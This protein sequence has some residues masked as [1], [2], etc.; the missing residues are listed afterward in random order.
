M[1]SDPNMYSTFG[2]DVK[3]TFSCQVSSPSELSD[4][5]FYD[6]TEVVAATRRTF[7]DGKTK[8]ELDL[9]V[10][11]VD[12]AGTYSCR[13][14]AEETSSTSTL[15]VMSMLKELPSNVKENP[16]TE[17]VLTCRAEWNTV[18]ANKPVFTWLKDGTTATETQID[19]EDPG[20]TWVESTLP[21]TLSGNAEFSCQATYADLDAGSFIIS[22]TTVIANSATV[23][24]AS[25]QIKRVGETAQF[26]CVVVAGPSV[27]IKWRKRAD[28]YTAETPKYTDLTASSIQE[29]YDPEKSSRKSTLTVG[30]GNTLALTDTSDSIECYDS[31]L[32]ISATMEL[33]VFEITELVSMGVVKEETA[34]L[35]CSVTVFDK[36]PVVTW[37]KKD[38]IA[39]VLEEG[40]TSPRPG[41]Y[42]LVIE[43]AEEIDNG[44]YYCKVTYDETE[45]L[46]PSTFK[47][48]EVNFYVRELDPVPTTPVYIHTGEAISLDCTVG[49]VEEAAGSSDIKWYKDGTLV[50]QVEGVVKVTDHAYDGVNKNQKITYTDTAVDKDDG[51]VY[52]CE[53]NFKYGDPISFE[54]KVYVHL[55]TALDEAYSN[56]TELSCEFA[57]S[58]EPTITWWKVS[59]GEGEEEA[60]LK[61]IDPS[62]DE[63]A[64]FSLTPGTWQDKTV[65][66]KLNIDLVKLKDTTVVTCKLVFTDMVETEN[67]DVADDPRPLETQTTINKRE[68]T[69]KTET[70]Y[71]TGGLVTMECTFFYGISGIG[72]SSVEWTG[73]DS[74]AEAEHV[75]DEG[76]NTDGSRTT[77]LKFPDTND[78][79]YSGT[80][81]CN[82]VYSDGKGNT[83]E[84]YKE[85]IEVITRLITVDPDTQG[86][87]HTNAGFSVTCTFAGQETPSAVTWTRDGTPLT[88]GSG[89]YTLEYTIGEKKAELAKT[90]PTS[91]DDGVYSCTFTMETAGDSP[92]GSTTITV[93]LLTMTQSENYYGAVGG[94]LALACSM[95]SD[96]VV[97]IYWFKDGLLKENVAEEQLIGGVLSSTLLITELSAAEDDGVYSC[98]LSNVADQDTHMETSTTTVTLTTL[99]FTDEPPAKTFGMT[100]VD[101]RIT[102]KTNYAKDQGI[103]VDVV[104]L[105]NDGSEP[106]VDG[107]KF[108]SGAA[109]SGDTFVS[110]LT[111]SYSADMLEK[112]YS[113][114]FTFSGEN[115]GTSNS[116]TSSST[117]ISQM[118]ISGLED[119]MYVESGKDVTFSCKALGGSATT[120]FWTKDGGEYTSEIVETPKWDEE[121]HSISSTI[122]I[123]GAG[124]EDDGLY[125]CRHSGDPSVTD[126][127]TVDV[128]E[129]VL[130]SI[131]VKSDAS[132]T[133]TCTVKDITGIFTFAWTDAN[134]DSV[135]AKSDTQID[136]NK[137]MDSELTVTP[138]SD[139][140]Y[141]CTVTDPLGNKADP[142]TAN[143]KVFEITTTNAKVRT[144]EDAVLTC[145]ISGITE[146]VTVV[147]SDGTQDLETESGVR[148]IDPGTPLGAGATTQTATMTLY[149][150]ET[151]AIFICKV[152]SGEFPQSKTQTQEVAVNLFGI[153]LNTKYTIKGAGDS[154]DLV[155]TGEGG[156][157][158]KIEW[159][160]TG[161]EEVLDAVLGDYDPDSA[162]RT[163]TFSFTNLK[164]S[165]S[166]EYTCTVTFGEGADEKVSS[167]T[168]IDVVEITASSDIGEKTG[169]DAV[170]SCDYNTFSDAVPT[171]KWFQVN[172]AGGAD[173]EQQASLVDNDAS[174]KSIL[175]L[176]SVQFDQSGQ[177]YYCQIEYQETA[178]GASG[179]S[180]FES[181]P[182]T[183]Y[184]REFVT[185]APT[186]TYVHTG[187][188]VSLVCDLKVKTEAELE[189][190]KWYK[191][192]V[193]VVGVNLVDTAEYDDVNTLQKTTY[194]DA[195]PDKTEGGVYKC[196]YNFVVG[197]AI[198]LEFT[199]A[200]HLLTKLP[201]ITLNKETVRCEFKGTNQPVITWYT[202]ADQEVETGGESPYTTSPGTW[203]NNAV[204]ATLSIDKEKYKE[205]AS[206]TCK[207]IFSPADITDPLETTTAVHFREISVQ[208]ETTYT[209]GDD[210]MLSCVFDFTKGGTG[211]TTVTWS[212]VDSL[213]V[214][215]E[216]TLDLGSNGADGTRTSTLTLKNIDEAKYA[217]DYVCNFGYSDTE[218]Y[219]SEEIDVVVRLVKVEATQ[220]ANTPTNFK[221]TC[222]FLGTEKPTSVTWSFTGENDSDPTPVTKDSADF[223]LALIKE[224]TQAVLTKGSPDDVDTGEYTCEWAF[225]DNPNL[226]TSGTQNLYVALLKMPQKDA[227]PIHSP[228][229]VAVTVTCTVLAAETRN[230]YWYKGDT[231]LGTG[232]ETFQD[233]VVTSEYVITSFSNSDLGSY[234]CRLTNDGSTVTAARDS[235]VLAIQGLETTPAGAGTVYIEEEK[236]TTLSCT[237][238]HRATITWT[239]DSVTFDAAEIYDA[240]DY[241]SETDSTTS[242][243]SF[244]S[245]TADNEGVYVCTYQTLS[246]TFTIDTFGVEVT[247][248]EVK[249]GEETEL[250]CKVTGV[251]SLFGFAWTNQDSGS[252]TSEDDEKVSAENEVT[253]TVTV[254]PTGDTTYTCSITDPNGAAAASKTVTL[255]VFEITDPVETIAVVGTATSLVCGVTGN[256]GTPSYKWYKVGQDTPVFTDPGNEALS[257]Y[258]ISNPQF[259]DDGAYKCTVAMTV[260]DVTNDAF[261]SNTAELIVKLFPKELTASFESETTVKATTDFLQCTYKGDNDVSTV[262]W[263]GPGGNIDE[264][265]V[266]TAEY[267]EEDNTIVTKFTFTNVAGGDAGDYTC[268]FNFDEASITPMSKTTSVTIAVLTAWD[269]ITLNEETLDCTFTGTHE[270]SSLQWY[271]G[272]NVPVV[273]TQGSPYSI[274]DGAFTDNTQTSTLTIDKALYTD[275]TTF[276]CKI[277][278]TDIF[279]GSSDGLSISTAVHFREIK[280]FTPTTYTTGEDVTI[281]CVLDFTK[282]GTGPTSVEWTQIGGLAMSDDYNLDLGTNEDD[283]TRTTTLKLKG[284]DNVKFAKLYTC[285][286]KYS[287][288]ET[289]TQS[290]QVNVRVATVD[291]AAQYV[292][293]NANFKITCDLVGNE[294]PTGV[295]WTHRATGAAETTPVTKDTA[296]FTLDF[297]DSTFQAILTKSSPGSG[298]DGEYTCEY[299]FAEETAIK[300]TNK[301]TIV[302]AL[303]QMPQHTSSPINKT[304]G[305]SVV[306]TCTVKSEVKLDIFWYKGATLVENDFEE[307]LES[308]VV[309][310]EL[311]INSI[312]GADTG[313]YSCRLDSDGSLLRI[314]EQ[315]VLLKLQGLETTPAAA[316]NVYTKLS[317][318]LTLECKIDN[319]GTVTWT[320]D[321]AAFDDGAIYSAGTYN[322]QDDS[323]TS[324]LTFASVSQE[325]AGVY[326]CTF[327]SLSA[328]FTI[329][330]FDISVTNK[331]VESGAET[332]LTC[333]VSDITAPFTF[334]WTD[335]DGNPVES[336]SES[337]ADENNEQESELT[338]T[339]DSDTTYQCT[340]TDASL[341]TESVTATLNVFEITPPIDVYAEVGTATSL[342]CGV[343]GNSGTP[344]YKWYKVGQDTPV[345]T[346][347][348]NEALSVYAISDPQFSD[349]GEYFCRVAL[350]VGDYTSDEYDS[351]TANI[352]TRKLTP[353]FNA[354][355]VVKT[356]SQS[357]VCTYKGDNDVTTVVWSGPDG[358][359]EDGEKI[360]TSSYEEATRTLVSTFTFSDFGGGDGGSYKCTFNFNNG[361]PISKST[362]VAIYSLSQ[363]EARYF[364]PEEI[365]VTFEGTFEPTLTWYIGGV[366]YDSETNTQLTTSV[367]TPWADNS[368][369]FKIALRMNSFGFGMQPFT[370]SA[371]VTFGDESS[372][373]LTTED[374]K[375]YK[376]ELIEQLSAKYTITG[377][378]QKFVC[379]ATGEDNTIF[380]IKWYLGDVLL[381]DSQ[382]HVTVTEGPS[383]GS[384]YIRTGTLTV[385][386]T[387]ADFS[388]QLKCSVTWP[389]PAA[390]TVESVTEVSARGAYMEGYS[391]SD[392]EGDGVMVCSAWKPPSQEVTFTWKTSDGNVL[393]AVENEI[394]IGE[395]SADNMY[396]SIVKILDMESSDSGDYKCEVAFGDNEPIVFTTNLQLISVK[397]EH[398]G[399][400]YDTA[401]VDVGAELLITCTYS[402]EEN[403]KKVEW[404]KGTALKGTVLTDQDIT[405]EIT[406]NEYDTDSS[407]RQSVLKLRKSIVSESGVYTCQWELE[408]GS[409]TATVNVNIMGLH[410]TGEVQDKTYSV[411][412]TPVISCKY[413]G[414]APGTVTW[415]KGGQSLEE[416]GVDG[417]PTDGELQHNMATYTLTISDAEAGVTDGEYSCKMEWEDGYS[418]SV[419]TDLVVRVASVVEGVS[420]SP[421]SHLV[422]SDGTV[423]MRCLY[424]GVDLPNGVQWFYGDVEINFGVTGVEIKNEM[425]SRVSDKVKNYQ[426]KITLED[427][428]MSDDGKYSCRF[429]MDDLQ[430]PTAEAAVAIVTVT[431]DTCVFVDYGVSSTKSV[432]CTYTGTSP[433]LS[434]KKKFP[435]GNEVAG[436]LSEVNQNSQT[437]SFEL[438]DITDAK[439]GTYECLFYLPNNLMVS[440]EIK[441]AAR[442]AVLSTSVGTL[443]PRVLTRSSI[444]ITCTV[445]SGAKSITW[446]K[447]DTEFTSYETVEDTDSVYS[448]SFDIEAGSGGEYT[449]RGVYY[450]D[451]CPTQ[452]TFP[453]VDTINLEV[454]QATANKQ[455]ADVTVTLGEST[456]FECVFPDPF[457]QSQEPQPVIE[458]RVGKQQLLGDDFYLN[459]VKVMDG[460]VSNKHGPGTYTTVLTIAEVTMEAAGDYTCTVKWGQYFIHSEPATL[461]VRA[462]ATPT[463]TP[464][465]PA[466]ADAKLT[467][468]AQSDSVATISFHKSSDDSSVV[469]VTSTDDSD[470]ASSTTIT[471]TG[472]LTV[473]GVS[474]SDAVNY[475]CKATWGDVSIKSP[476]VYL[477]VLDVVQ[478][479][480]GDKW[481]VVGNSAQ[482][483]CYYNDRLMESSSVALKDEDGRDVHAV[484]SV[485]WEYDK[486]GTWTDI[487]DNNMIKAGGSSR[488]GN[489]RIGIVNVGPLT[490]ADTEISIRC[491]V[492]YTADPTFHLQS[493]EI[494]SQPV[495]VKVIRVISFAVPSSLTVTGDTVTLSCS[496]TGPTKPTFSFLADKTALPGIT[497]FSEVS[498]ATSV[499]DPG[500]STL[501]TSEYQVS[502]AAPNI[503]LDGQA[504]VCQAQFTAGT[505][506]SAEKELKTYYNCGD[507]VIKSKI[508]LRKD[509]FATIVFGSVE[510]DGS[511]TASTQCKP[512]SDSVK[513]NIP[514][515]TPNMAST[516]TCSKDTG[517]W[518]P[519]FLSPCLQI[520]VFSEAKITQKYDLTDWD[521]DEICSAGAAAEF[522]EEKI[523]EYLTGTDTSECGAAKVVPC[524]GQ[525]TCTIKTEQAGGPDYNGC[526]WD[527]ATKKLSVFVTVEFTSAIEKIQDKLDAVTLAEGD[528]LRY[529]DCDGD[530][531]N[532]RNA[533][534]IEI[535][536]RGPVDTRIVMKNSTFLDEEEEGPGFEIKN[537]SDDEMSA[538]LRLL[539]VVGAVC[540]AALLILAV[541]VLARRRITRNSKEFQVEIFPGKLI[542]SDA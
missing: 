140:T 349:E 179:P 97:N 158:I 420:N 195:V 419:N 147:F 82:F 388:G 51:G 19:S 516:S 232:V 403:P 16:G 291:Q 494:T 150:V 375:I 280:T 47:S 200:V 160:E 319:Q 506:S 41:I 279:P 62:K 79:K 239:K 121:T 205:I 136:E 354:E 32:E 166:K 526:S 470:S 246:A 64:A 269:P 301:A 436:E 300:A 531:T 313:E 458:W 11:G 311:S 499:V 348:G 20:K 183:L 162:T 112:S 67:E 471:T 235:V 446:Y 298:D 332:V 35:T 469:T 365:L 486:S 527:K 15:S 529:W 52:K 437:G 517:T 416:A 392:T 501:F 30:S 327:E 510:A 503:I 342:V 106:D 514:A 421:A 525:E 78:G 384:A 378:E 481:E 361:D 309:S 284:I 296:D 468:M 259:S 182:K 13:K 344:S 497:Y 346:D 334:S 389:E 96:K 368:V 128:Y 23:T 515:A 230:I 338:V 266:D 260:G 126:S 336:L 68:F 89:D 174:G 251:T 241:D 479:S 467:C 278:F 415:L 376:R 409:P 9:M 181:D 152:T 240:G 356:S 326:I 275:V 406:T 65:T 124:F 294:T 61:Q 188:T 352:V 185:A 355:T 54:I 339:P 513:Y 306:L 66:D 118:A 171:V 6:G 255:N 228:P 387:R 190:V 3:V 532:K 91:A 484:T 122:T 462:I 374:A 229:G 253:S 168:K 353:S 350:T 157:N 308:K 58:N 234:S 176:S 215:E 80:Y 146:A 281:S 442:R 245:V 143:L 292:H 329:D 288:T 257:V 57:G 199:V 413:S 519:R 130:K 528:K 512:N 366:E 175:T 482:Q 511:L 22:K 455:P 473:T 26:T 8:V 312:S 351:D 169:E 454:I 270:P 450:D 410:I 453:S 203:E 400:D 262:V 539:L 252:V 105:V 45:D 314:S 518:T 167:K 398:D 487:A 465:V 432:Q 418:K 1:L 139:T 445:S 4:L 233:G 523:V 412:G 341:G 401:H 492:T 363:L 223:D 427:K 396:T 116:I 154:Q 217:G 287:D 444:T 360:V 93:G 411:D 498:A 178:S 426:S 324:S 111:I 439:T 537:R 310:S 189:S 358:D 107:D 115:V 371:K 5:D 299:E 109:N 434:F 210:V 297:D 76:T 127:V 101:V 399:P 31:A 29:N 247:N 500:D 522:T 364:S 316:G 48:E 177:Q 424:E 55:L 536:D 17:V 330:V 28:D 208:S 148:L 476:P 211:P 367:A 507:S 369:T 423:E 362:N 449:C 504:I 372:E 224:N 508:K 36:T 98:S 18:D 496:A 373:E 34:T 386:N 267:S 382:D 84:D 440:A 331:E 391:Y 10:D 214:T 524:L 248:K 149:G 40:G 276:T 73:L 63:F 472:V 435:K 335:K 83:V 161:N 431:T 244:S 103:D 302:V 538:K 425:L 202:G 207:V 27:D 14:S 340:V 159:T 264:A 194:E 277:S 231:L 303:L 25:Y 390:Y 393:E 461:T 134:S 448:I 485:A 480:M 155:C 493:G 477:S 236:S 72:P 337:V 408:N 225:T 422:F 540:F 221:I 123:T 164:V 218:S 197:E 216:Y 509:D 343:T 451:N 74:I 99:D 81:T 37:F 184:V 2:D 156:A 250:V 407:S 209:I 254:T 272:E 322:Q 237:V 135:T 53:F 75:I 163:S 268:T 438:L 320:K 370:V 321:G 466:G 60:T 315:R 478:S 456:R 196:E 129:V 170:F 521:Q 502:V 457:G 273:T 542:I 220:Y 263:T 187:D 144:G 463:S 286:F 318:S 377:S 459:G 108:F 488:E 180:T 165:D 50:E 404:L 88:S 505:V 249:S 534:L 464:N 213:T 460:S 151:D 46:G 541:T 125:V 42:E 114:K 489:L 138:D 328:T 289:Y 274:E 172:S 394:E 77:T 323:Q 490:S 533:L 119:K 90:N 379:K 198:S 117:A 100:G 86:F 258:S 345:F 397:I 44:V 359:I 383:G 193:E 12:K 417:T 285:G 212:G 395:T 261:E 71:T 304:P 85:T 204:T 520:T 110:S 141:T 433:A 483:L 357:F 113:C 385:D 243:L 307:V 380:S 447:D 7:E 429:H 405:Y 133:L 43:T 491:K 192:S 265:E 414:T 535:L 317:S 227:S 282:G 104:W 293:T 430:D 295:T 186:P 347:P 87:I 428:T 206:I 495:K 21:V 290:I 49:I 59:Q 94:S 38:S 69:S 256:S 238:S 191:D 219:K 132:A 381:E 475:Y 530:G 153:S 33:D 39:D 271:T 443:S 333:K 102:C 222:D 137:N 452:H 70:V 283:G 325:N 95:K 56:P 305:Q 92:A 226:K 441:L 402:G 201:D 142:K 242:T 24:P 120:I 474:A 145:E 131:E 173:V